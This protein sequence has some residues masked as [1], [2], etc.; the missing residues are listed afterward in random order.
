[1]DFSLNIGTTG[2]KVPCMS[3]IRAEA[4]FRPDV[5]LAVN[6]SPPALLPELKLRPG[7]DII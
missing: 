3:P 2:S 4:T 1:L 5:T 6:R 7:S